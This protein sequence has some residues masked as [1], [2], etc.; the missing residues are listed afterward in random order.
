MKRSPSVSLN[1]AE[2][3]SSV[4]VKRSERRCVCQRQ[5][6]E[7][8]QSNTFLSVCGRQGQDIYM[9]IHYYWDEQ[10]NSQLLYS[11][12]V[13]ST[14]ACVLYYSEEN[15]TENTKR[16]KKMTLK[17]IFTLTLTLCKLPKE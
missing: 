6:I 4:D 7:Q 5:E 10:M 9:K 13:S 1:I 14:Q 17:I 2:I 3:V 11:S 16:E 12:Y 8:R 15:Q